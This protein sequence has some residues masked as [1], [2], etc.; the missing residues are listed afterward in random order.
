MR[1]ILLFGAGKSATVLIDF[2]L[3][4]ALAENWI[5]TVV[6]ANLALAQSK[7]GDALGGLAVA[8]DTTNEEKRKAYIQDA[9]IVISL[10]PPSLHF[11][12]AQDCLAYRKNLLT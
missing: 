3:R 4:N 2:L 12:V 5:L 8:F 6:D 11:L 10:L 7:I 9:D 1:K